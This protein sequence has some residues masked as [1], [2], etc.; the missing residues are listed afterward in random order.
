[1]N[2]LQGLVYVWCKNEGSRWF[3][4]R[5]LGGVNFDWNGTPLQALYD[6]HQRR[7]VDHNQAIKRAGIDDG[8]LLKEVLSEDRRSF[9]TR[10]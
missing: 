8:W 9:E 4:A 3:S 5:D 7:R 6:Y 2:Y 10:T 1:M